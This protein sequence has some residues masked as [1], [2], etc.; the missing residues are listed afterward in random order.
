MLTLFARNLVNVR[1]GVGMKT[2]RIFFDRIRTRGVDPLPPPTDLPWPPRAEPYARR[3]EEGAAS[4]GGGVRMR[5]RARGGG[6]RRRRTSLGAGDER[7]G[8]TEREASRR[9][10]EWRRA[11][12]LERASGGCAG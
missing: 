9:R 3:R 10:V 2:V 11:C 6:R 5:A 4:G 7:E 1:L 8:A 12:W